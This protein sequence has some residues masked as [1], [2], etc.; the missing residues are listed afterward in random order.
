LDSD[1]QST[2]FVVGLG[3][4]GQEYRLTRH[5]L[6]FRVAEALARRWLAGPGKAAFGGRLAEAR[7]RRGDQERRVMLF[8]PRTHM[9]C[10]G[11]AVREL[12]GFYQAPLQDVLIVL[13]DLAMDLG[14]LRLRAKGS[15]GGHKGLADVIAALGSRELPRLRIGIGSPP[16]GMDAVDYVLQPFRPDELET[17]EAAVRQAADAV[18]DWLFEG[19]A[20]AMD[21]HNRKLEQSS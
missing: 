17:V 2:R 11:Q 15:A 9:N 19:L 5:N 14:R 13:D 20:P 10:S 1:H 18:E 8:W 4:P 16:G 7:R 21:K 3:N 6:G 12:V